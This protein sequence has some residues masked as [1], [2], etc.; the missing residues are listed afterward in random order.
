MIT[1]SLKDGTT[2]LGAI[3]ESDLRFLIENLEEED[4]RDTDYFISPLTIDMLE[5]KGASPE[6]LDL[7]KR[8]VGGSD[9]VDVVWRE[10]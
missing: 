6:L 8:A 9:G 7:L 4:E 2:P 3:A 5:E 1:L 10:T